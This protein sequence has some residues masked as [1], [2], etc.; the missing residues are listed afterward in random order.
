MFNNLIKLATDTITKSVTK[1]IDIP[2]AVL[3]ESLKD[4]TGYSSKRLTMFASFAFCIISAGLDQFTGYKLNPDVFNNFLLMSGGL[5][6]LS[7]IDKR[8]I[9]NDNK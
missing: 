2:K 9:K 6:G 1:T 3:G 8:S 5:G 4:D 7:V